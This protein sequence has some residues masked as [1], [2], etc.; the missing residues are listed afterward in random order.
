MK[1]SQLAASRNAEQTRADFVVSLQSNKI[2][3]QAGIMESVTALLYSTSQTTETVP[4]SLHLAPDSPMSALPRASAHISHAMLHRENK[5]IAGC[6]PHNRQGSAGS[7]WLKIIK[8]LIPAGQYLDSGPAYIGRL[9]A[10][11][12][13]LFRSQRWLG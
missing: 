1:K 3:A 13:P 11:G 4:Q 10:V 7:M 6:A 2:P 12:S 9:T 8:C 5:V